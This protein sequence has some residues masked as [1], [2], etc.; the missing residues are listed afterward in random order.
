[1][2]NL[3]KNDV[4]SQVKFTLKNMKRAKLRSPVIDVTVKKDSL[5]V[6]VLNFF[7]PNDNANQ[8]ITATVYERDNCGA[9]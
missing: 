9:G 7:C 1:M 3:R 4:D 8:E 6:Y 2:N 5:L